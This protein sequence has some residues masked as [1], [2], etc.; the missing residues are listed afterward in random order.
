MPDGQRTDGDEWEFELVKAIARRLPGLDREVFRPGRKSVI[1]NAGL[2]VRAWRGRYLA[3]VRGTRVDGG[4]PVVAFGSGD[5]PLL[6]LR[7]V[8]TACQKREFKVDRFAPFEQQVLPGMADKV[9]TLD[10][11]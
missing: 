2:S 1:I 9:E 7:N 8:S 6:A 10:G 11:S 5:S 3:V 4:G